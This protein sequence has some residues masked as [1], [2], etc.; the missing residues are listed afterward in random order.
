MAL[1]LSEEDV[2]QLLTMP[3]AMDSLEA[4]FRDQ[5]EGEAINQP[6]QRFFLTRSV[7]HHMAAVW[8]SAGVMGTKTYVEVRGEKRFYIQL[9]STDT[10]HLL[11]YIEGNRLSQVR[12][13]AA[14]GVAARYMARQDS[15]TV[16]L[17]GTGLQAR[18]QA[19]ALLVARPGIRKFQVYGRD[20]RRRTA[21][22][23]EMTFTTGVHFEPMDSPEAT[24]RGAQIVVTAT[25]AIE[26]IL[27]GAW[28]STGA[29]VAAIGANAIS[30]REIDEDVVD[31]APRVV[32]DDIP[33]AE[34]EAG[35]LIFAYEKGKF[36]WKKAVPLAAVVV[37][38]VPGRTDDETVTL[39][40]SLG[41][42]LEDIAVA[43]VVFE[44]AASQGVGR[45]L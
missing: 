2:D 1:F 22:C 34:I 27:K 33:Q 37:G 38:R 6:R 44:L 36:R 20:Y 5:A 18:T 8:P 21:F 43:K 3:L 25:S 12:T 16:G 30:E 11:A 7:L 15:R 23:Q 19:E 9:F 29:F 10:G 17:Y 42:A 45:K 35:E 28:I 31:R 14:T 40:K 13:G 41:V 24:A 32:V 26:P 4:A 39:F